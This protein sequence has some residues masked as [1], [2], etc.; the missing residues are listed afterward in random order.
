MLKGKKSVLVRPK[1]SSASCV[2]ERSERVAIM[3]HDISFD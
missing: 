2:G 3:V 1:Y